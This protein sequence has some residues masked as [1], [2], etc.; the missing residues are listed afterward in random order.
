MLTESEQE[1]STPH[2]G[3]NMN[4]LAATIADR[5]FDQLLKEIVYYKLDAQTIETVLAKFN[6]SS[7]TISVVLRLWSGH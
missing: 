1:N 3:E 5:L 2:V 4:K 6:I 7:E